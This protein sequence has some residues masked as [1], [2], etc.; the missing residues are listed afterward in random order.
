MSKLLDDKDIITLII[1]RLE[2][3]YS[4][5]GEIKI[6]AAKQEEN[7]KEHMR[8]SDLLEEEVNL[9]KTQLKPLQNYLVML[10]GLAKALALI[11]VAVSIIAG[12]AKISHLF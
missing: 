11:G 5:V 2:S 12:L 4:D 7:L 9:L 3:I 6:T 10:Q 1:H 8:R